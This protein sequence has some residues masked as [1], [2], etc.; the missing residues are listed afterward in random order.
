[1]CWISFEVFDLVFVIKCKAPKT[2]SVYICAKFTEKG[3]AVL[4]TT[5]Q[6]YKSTLPNKLFT[7]NMSLLCR[8]NT[9]DQ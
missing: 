9:E 7:K 6:K 1:M 2:S 5:Q 3:L 4:K 8:P